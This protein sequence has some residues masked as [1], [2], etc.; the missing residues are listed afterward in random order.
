LCLLATAHGSCPNLHRHRGLDVRLA[1]KV[2]SHAYRRR[3]SEPGDKLL[4]PDF[5]PRRFSCPN[6]SPST[7][8]LGPFMEMD[9]SPAFTCNRRVQLRVWFRGMTA[10]LAARRPHNA[11]FR[12]WKFGRSP[13]HFLLE[14][15][16]VQPVPPLS[17]RHCVHSTL[18][19]AAAAPELCAH[20]RQ[21]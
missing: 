19:G 17:D 14:A 21:L 4:K 20:T 16:P 12:V 10:G 11:T 18:L 5:I 7:D 3:R 15:C 2:P 8:H 6:S 1:I 9:S 13:H